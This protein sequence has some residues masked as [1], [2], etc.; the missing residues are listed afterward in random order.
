MELDDPKFLARLETLYLLAR[1]VIGGSLAADRRSLKKG[2]GINFA[3]YSEYQYGDDYRNI[4]WNIYARLETLVIKLFEL[5]EDVSIHIFLDVSRSMEKKIHYAKQIAAAIAY[6]ALC[7]QDKLIIDTIDD[8]LNSLL[9]PCR[10]KG[11]VMSLINNLKTIE[12]SGNDTKFNE[13]IELFQRRQKQSEV[14]VII[15][16][17]FFTGGYKKGLQQMKY[18][19]NDVYCV[20]VLDPEEV[21]CDYLGDLEIQCIET[22]KKRKLTIGPKEQL[23]YNELMKQW[24]EGL[25]KECSK[26]EIGYIQAFTDKPFDEIIRDILSKGGLIA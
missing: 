16:D 15:S 18:K 14:C 9:D 26:Y 8:K 4:D 1:R 10:G 3:D 23:K 21:K 6:I 20:Q 13:A 11:K 7:N 12:L 22:A 19:K 2:S 25:N 5:E 24:N 17:F